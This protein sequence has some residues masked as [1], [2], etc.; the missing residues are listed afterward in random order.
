ML[1]EETKKK[2]FFRLNIPHYINTQKQI[3]CFSKSTI[4]CNQSGE[5]QSKKAKYKSHEDANLAIA[6]AHL[7]PYLPLNLK[8]Y[9]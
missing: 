9:L 1:S 2:S 3:Y 8:T 6:Y 5:L 7:F 4:G